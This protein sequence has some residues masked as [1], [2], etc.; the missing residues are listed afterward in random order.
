MFD[1]H[2]ICRINLA[3]QHRKYA[4][5]M[6]ILHSPSRLG[7]KVRENWQKRLLINR[8]ESCGDENFRIFLFIYIQHRIFFLKTPCLH[9][10][11]TATATGGGGGVGEIFAQCG[12]DS[13]CLFKLYSRRSDN[14]QSDNCESDLSN[15][16]CSSYPSISQFSEVGGQRTP[17]QDGA[18]SAGVAWQSR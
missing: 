2:L 13:D 5:I 17:S 12:A 9:A 16:H 18:S 15:S 14:L 1:L 4:D 11:A 8:V 6:G 7:E 10:G 3:F